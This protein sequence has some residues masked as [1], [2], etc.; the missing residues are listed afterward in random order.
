M[1]P[2][3]VY[4]MLKQGANINVW[5]TN[6]TMQIQ[7]MFNLEYWFDKK[8]R[9]KAPLSTSLESTYSMKQIYSLIFLLNTIIYH[10]L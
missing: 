4:L 6:S 2:F 8:P 3:G 1:S 5:R 10:Q 7:W 9:I